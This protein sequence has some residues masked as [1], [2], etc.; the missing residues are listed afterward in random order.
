MFMLNKISESES[1]C[2]VVSDEPDKPTPDLCGLSARTVVY[3][4]TLGLFDLEVSL[5]S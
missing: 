2:Y 5:V 4:G 3:A 1:E